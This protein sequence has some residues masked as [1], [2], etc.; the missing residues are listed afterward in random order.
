M[1]YRLLHLCL[2]GT[3]LSCPYN[4]G[5]GCACEV[6]EA[7]AV[8]SAEHTH[9]CCG[10]DHCTRPELVMPAASDSQSD[11]RTPICPEGEC[12]SDCLCKGAITKPTK[13]LE[14][15]SVRLQGIVESSILSTQLCATSCS[16]AA[17]LLPHVGNIF[18]RALRIDQMSFL[19]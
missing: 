12:F 16:L 1:F 18:G 13:L 4:C 15:R 17:G 10:K 14:L 11:G 6:T 8:G 5:E 2:V 19:I 3:L 9:E 7:G